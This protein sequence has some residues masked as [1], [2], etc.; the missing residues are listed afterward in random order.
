MRTGWPCALT[1]VLRDLP[2]HTIEGV[3]T[4]LEALV[5]ADAAAEA[6]AAG[7]IVLAS[8]PNTDT[9]VLAHAPMLHR[10]ATLADQLFAARLAQAV[11]QLGAAAAS[12]ELART[13]LGE[14]LGAEHEIDAEVSGEPPSLTV[15]VK[16]AR[17]RFQDARME[18]IGF[19]VRLA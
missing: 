19:T 13:A 8:A 5:T 11:R 7:V 17:G 9:A 1:G 2:V 18:E 4:P 14:L 12:V 10:P 16:P 6:A 3:A 15:I